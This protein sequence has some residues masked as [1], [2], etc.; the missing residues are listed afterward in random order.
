MLEKLATHDVQDISELFNIVDKCARA[1][2][3]CAWHSQHVPEEGKANKPNVDAT[4]QSS[5]KTKKKKKVGSNKSLVDA[6]TSTATVA[7][8]GGGRCLCGDKRSWQP[9]GSDEGG[10]CCPVHNSMHY[11]TE[12]C[13][14]IK[15]LTEQFHEQQKQ[16]L[17]NDSMT[18]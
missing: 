11:N 17:R 2:E 10:L 16:Q 3:G 1:P 6:P 9:S 4:A 12:E 5:G 7:A 18:P 15:K 14:E 8:V 13:W